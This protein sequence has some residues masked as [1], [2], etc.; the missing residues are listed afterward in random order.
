MYLI[1]FLSFVCLISLISCGTTLYNAD[2]KRMNTPSRKG[3]LKTNVGINSSVNIANAMVDASFSPKDHIGVQVFSDLGRKNLSIG[4]AIGGYFGNYRYQENNKFG[5]H[6]DAYLG[7]SIEKVGG[8]TDYYLGTF[9]GYNYT[10]QYHDISA[11]LGWHLKYGYFG[12]DLV[13]RPHLLDVRKV[14][15]VGDVS[16]STK[17]HLSQLNNDPFFIRD[18]MGRISLSTNELGVYCAANICSGNQDVSEFLIPFSVAI[19][20]DIN[21]SKLIKE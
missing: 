6:F 1:K 18:F 14:T 2:S 20:F 13:F 4:G 12:V 9:E 11:Q 17:E 16:N 15:I 5:S 10:F 8:N 21:F 3:E 19:G 7:Y